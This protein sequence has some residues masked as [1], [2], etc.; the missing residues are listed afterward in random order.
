MAVDKRDQRINTLRR[1]AKRSNH[2]EEAQL[3]NQLAEFYERQARP[4][5]VMTKMSIRGET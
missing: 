4:D 1:L 5:L 3:F 2:H